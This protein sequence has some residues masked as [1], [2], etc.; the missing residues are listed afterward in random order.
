VDRETEEGR[1]G[2]N[3]S[4]SEHRLRKQEPR[5]V[6]MERACPGG[7]WGRAECRELGLLPGAEP[8]SGEWAQCG[9][10][11]CWGWAH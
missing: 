10:L 6:H 7:A 1:K 3:P 5:G 9:E 2:C 11:E 8:R 4:A